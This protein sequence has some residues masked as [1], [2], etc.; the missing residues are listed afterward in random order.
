[1]E[2]NESR[3]LEYISK[4]ILKDLTIIGHNQVLDWQ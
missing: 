1:M 4:Y 3:T 2:D